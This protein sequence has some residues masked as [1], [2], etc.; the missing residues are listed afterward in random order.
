MQ[1]NL[2]NYVEVAIHYGF[3][4][5]FAAALPGVAALAWISSY[6]EVKGDVWNLLHLHRRPT[7][8][9]AMD[10]GKWYV[11][12]SVLGIRTIDVKF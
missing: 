4:T 9:G 1:R 11:E 8:F 6:L 12:K 2:Q 5:M 10:I 3:V 7:P